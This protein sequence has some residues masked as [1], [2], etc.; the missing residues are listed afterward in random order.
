MPHTSQ[1]SMCYALR[2]TAEVQPDGTHEGQRSHQK[3]F[4]FSGPFCSQIT[5]T[6][7]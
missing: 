1:Q 5:A 3:Q 7:S 6:P 2:L 4:G